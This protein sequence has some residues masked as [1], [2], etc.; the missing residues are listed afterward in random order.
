[1]KKKKQS[2]KLSLQPEQ[3]TDVEGGIVEWL[4][5]DGATAAFV[6]GCVIAVYQDYPLYVLMTRDGVILGTDLV[7]MHT[8]SL[9]SDKSFF[10]LE[11]GDPNCFEQLRTKMQSYKP[12]A[13]QI[14]K[15]LD[16]MKKT[17]SKEDLEELV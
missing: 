15:L 5:S 12:T 17:T 8:S 1:M 4:L 13:A 2:M 6:R 11:L 14:K 10:S 3:P 7:A 16:T 9:P